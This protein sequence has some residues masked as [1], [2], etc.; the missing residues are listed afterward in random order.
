MESS[1]SI[2]G[3][4]LCK[5]VTIHVTSPKK[6]IGAC[7]C[8]MCRRWAAGPYLAMDCGTEVTFD[9]EDNIGVYDSSDW[10]DRGFC[11]KCGSSLFY[12]LKQNQQYIMS[13]G[14]FAEIEGLVFD[15][16]VFIEEK[17][18]YYE[19]ANKTHN[20]TGEE[21]FAAFSEGQE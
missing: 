12:R 1:E 6:S 2:S 16:Q 17:P 18:D 21:C 9:G 10:A 19:F 5:A 13:P 8:D 20:M 7:H 3:H 14:L 4:C 15:H 11:K